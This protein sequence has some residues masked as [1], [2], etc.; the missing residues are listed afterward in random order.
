VGLLFEHVSLL[1]SFVY[2]LALTHLLSSGTELVIARK[3]VRFSG[4]YALWAVNAATLLM[5][6]WVAIYSLT[7]LKQWTPIEIL[8]QFICAVVQY[9]TCSTFRVVQYA[10]D[11]V[12]DLTEIYQQR[13]L[14]IFTAFLALGLIVSFQN[15]WDRNNTKGM[16]PNDWIAVDLTIV[17]MIVAV[18]CA[19]LARPTWMQWVAGT[20]MFGLNLFF[21][22]HYAIPGS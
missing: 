20:A 17:P 13:R 1:L 9:F 18:I 15:W 3:R 6:N 4:L 2:A 21:F 22:L 11:D 5:I 8:I 16:G 19:G 10:E 7:A 14:L 12:V